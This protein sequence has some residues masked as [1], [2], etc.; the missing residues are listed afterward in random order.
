MP[1]LL[2]EIRKAI[3]EGKRIGCLAHKDADADSL[4]SALAFASALRADGKTVH[5]M[6]PS[7][8]PLLID[9]LPGF[10]SVSVSETDV[11]TLFTFDCPTPERFGDKQG[12]IQTVRTVINVDHHVT[13]DAFGTINLVDTSASATGQVVYA[14]LTEL[15]YD[16]SAGAATNLYAALFT[17]TGGFRH[18]N[19]NEAALRLGADLVARGADAG[20]VALK[21]Y[22]SRSIAQVHL[23]GMAITKLQSSHNGRL[24]HTEVTGAMLRQSGADSQEAEGVIDHLTEIASMK[25]AIVFRELNPS[26][27]KISVR[28]RDEFDATELCTQFGG[29]GH[30]RAA[31]AEIEL[32]LDEA[33]PKVLAA[34]GE[35]LRAAE[36]ESA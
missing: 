13:N 21:S 20:W 11:D 33:R 36:L 30:R 28:T 19:T 12:L 34:A 5:V 9:Y 24:V 18:E 3:D 29:G 31:G 23:E 32:P 8:M 17:D 35:I 16:I 27:T 7:P 1:A 2:P 14:L 26:L 22:K 10:D 6:V 25:I 15:N 4:G